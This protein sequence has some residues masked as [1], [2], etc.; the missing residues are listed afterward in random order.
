MDL[1][2]HIYH[3]IVTSSNIEIKNINYEKSLLANIMIK[4]CLSSDY[5]N[6]PI[7]ITDLVK[8]LRNSNQSSQ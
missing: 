2:Y 5:A 4:Y 3:L 7:N 6:I 1:L 8:E